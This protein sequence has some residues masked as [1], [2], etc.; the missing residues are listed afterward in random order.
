METS[1]D[2]LPMLAL[3][4]ASDFLWG[5]GTAVALLLVGLVVGAWLARRSQASP[6]A[7]ADSLQ[8]GIL[9]AKLSNWTNGFAVDMSHI[10]QVIDDAS[11]EMR[12]LENQPPD[13]A[14]QLLT[15]VA[16]ANEL[17]QQRIADAEQTLVEQ[18]QQLASYMNEARTDALTGLAN[19][20]AFDDELLRRMAEWQRL[21]TP[22]LMLLL[23]VDHFK[24]IND[25]YGH[26]AGDAALKQ[27]TAV[28]R[29]TLRQTDIAFRFGGEE[30][31]VLIPGQGQKHATEA[32]ERLRTIV[33]N[34]EFMANGVRL[35]VTISIGSVQ[36]L[37]NDH[38]SQLFKRADEA[39]YAAKHDGRN[40]SYWHDG[41]KCIRLS[42]P[43]RM[44][45]PFIAN[46]AAMA[47]PSDAV[48]A[49]SAATTNSTPLPQEPATATA[50]EGTKPEARP[51]TASE[52]GLV[53]EPVSTSDFAQV[54]A[55]LRRRLKEVTTK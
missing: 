9:L 3:L 7:S 4:A 24:R 28:L 10:K 43:D 44:S 36:P 51:M 46:L 2:M 12:H 31:I 30:F 33:R 22:F 17:L 34:T 21:D 13:R 45:T 55:D 38:A 25:T 16:A 23:D 47:K 19:R 27:L 11:T 29:A 40:C 53:N 35:P 15:Q 41:E 54:C 52:S 48:P 50:V 49:D 20:R 42:P 5:A 1:A 39:L 37:R 6:A 32:A 14:N 26:P 8:L 18:S